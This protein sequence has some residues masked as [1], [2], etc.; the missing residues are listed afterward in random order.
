M[1]C[2]NTFR[3]VAIRIK[4]VHVI[5]ITGFQESADRRC[6]TSSVLIIRPD[7]TS[8]KKI[9]H[10]KQRT[11]S[12]SCRQLQDM[13][14]FTANLPVCIALSSL[15]GFTNILGMLAVAYPRFLESK[16]GTVFG[17]RV[18]ALLLAGNLVCAFGTA[19][20]NLMASWYGPVSILVPAYMVS[21][22]LINML[23]LGAAR[24]QVECE[25]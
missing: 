23:M 11:A 20:I 8:S 4:I 7:Q 22:L 19:A 6:T 17:P 18:K 21:T 2:L 5:R 24:T 1:L 13:R 15:A 14:Q 9:A 16:R 25:F 3:S 12:S 10:R